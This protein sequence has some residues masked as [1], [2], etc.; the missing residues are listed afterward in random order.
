MRHRTA[1]PDRGPT[2]DWTYRETIDEA[3]ASIRVHG[4]VDRLGADLLRGTIE[5]LER[6][7]HRDITVT[8]DDT[9]RVDPVARAVLTAVAGHLA[10]RR[11]RL[12][13]AWTDG[14]ITDEQATP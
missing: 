12:T 8:I 13:I 10:G 11:G 14:G 1:P 7:G 3:T 4:R 2:S 5:N 6:R 9:A